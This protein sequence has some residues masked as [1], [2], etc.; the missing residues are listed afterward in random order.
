MKKL[1]IILVLAGLAVGGGWYFLG[2]RSQGRITV[3]KT[4]VAEQGSVSRM[5][6][7]TGIVKAQ[8][9]AQLKIGARATGTLTHV[10]VKVGDRVTRG[11]L[12]AE[13]DSREI[14]AKIAEAR[15]QLR[16]AQ[17]KAEYTEK[18]LPRQKTLVRKKLESQDTLDK[19]IQDALVARR[20]VDAAQARLSTLMVQL[21]YY[22]IVSPI[23]GVVS[24]VTAQEGETIVS[25]LNV[26][27]LVTVLDPTLLEMWIYVDETDVGQVREGQP[28]EFTV[29]AFRDRVFKG[30]VDTVYPEPEIR[31]NIVYYR[32]LVRVS[33]EQAEWLRPEMTTQC[34]IVVETRDNVLTVPNTALKW[35]A[36]QQVCYVVDS[37]DREP[38]EVRPELGL[39]GLDRTQVTGGLKAGDVVATQLVLPGRK[40]GQKGL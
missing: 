23:D 1:V 34:K 15:A 6:E 20:E 39:A 9:G 37:P 8:V 12:L 28:V 33:R 7:A 19:A 24:Q 2:S 30:K 17:A 5:L 36:G 38:R 22:R 21:S 26:S 3:L 25:G 11:Q 4:A 27:N 35:V 13:V 10:P 40:M 32:A 14:R 16:L 29:D 31:D 18:N